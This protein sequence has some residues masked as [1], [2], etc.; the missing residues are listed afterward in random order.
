MQR[1]PDWE[2]RL[3]SVLEDSKNKP[4]IWGKHDCCHFSSACVEAM[5]GQN[6]IFPFLEKYHDKSSARD[7]LR[8]LGSGSLLKTLIDI[9]GPAI[10]PSFGRRGDV[11]FLVQK[12]GPSVGI[13]LGKFSYFVGETTGHEGLISIPTLEIKKIFR[14]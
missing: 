4:F 5:T 12:S 14:V 10:P 13:C 1:F 8:T 2:P 3:F 6:P 7:I 11:A 9:F